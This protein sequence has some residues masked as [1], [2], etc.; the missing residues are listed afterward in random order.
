[1][2]L[3]AWIFSIVTSQRGKTGGKT[4]KQ[5]WVTHKC[6]IKST[7]FSSVGLEAEYCSGDYTEL[8]SEGNGEKVI[9][10]GYIV[11]KWLNDF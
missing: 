2:S 11:N 5:F 6:Y 3:T 7:R 9:N 4:F 1:M 8:L 10:E